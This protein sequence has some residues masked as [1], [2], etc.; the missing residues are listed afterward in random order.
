MKKN[1]QEFSKKIGTDFND[2]NL[3]QQVFIHRSYLNEN[4]KAGLEHNERLEFLGDAVLELIVT[5]YLYKNFPNP[6]GEMTNWRAA[7]V[8]GEMLSKIATS[9]EMND[10]MLMS[11]GEQKSAGRARQIILANA[12]EALIGAIY[13]DL[14]FD[15]AKKF[16]DENVLTHLPE[17]LDKKLYIDAKSNLQEL[18]QSKEGVTPQYQVLEEKGPD[19]NKI[20]TV[21]VFVNEKMLAEGTG[22]SKQA[23]EQSAAA[24]ALRKID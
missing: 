8:R 6:E 13:L 15:S 4:K 3:L 2:L 17:I 24:E 1:Y 22:N 10:S 23:A 19:H 12:V 7:L 16:I 5:E 11:R 14:G 21:G 20:F 18:I 9:L